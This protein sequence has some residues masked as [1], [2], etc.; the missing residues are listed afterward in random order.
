[1]IAELFPEFY[2]VH[3]RRIL[4]PGRT[5]RRGGFRPTF[6]MGRYLT[7]PLEHRCGDFADMRKFLRSCRYSD[8]DR[9]DKT[10]YW[11]PPEEFEKTRTGDC[12]DFA[13][14][15]W[16]QVLNMGY[17]ARFVVG[18]AGKF[19]EGHA[20]VT[21]ERDGK[22]YLL[23]ALSSVVGLQLPRISTL[24][25]HPSTSASWEGES[26]CYYAHAERDTNVPLRLLP[27]LVGEWIFIWARFWA[28]VGPR[29]PY[30]ILRRAL[31]PTPASKSRASRRSGS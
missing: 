6:P 24:R 13:A 7:A 11:Q 2:D 18:R 4:R 23:E 3:G 26:V 14:W 10:D 27:S 16:R 5:Q 15:A 1:M 9:Y 20:W 12:A 22:S 31:K 19:G 17:P 29:I 8:A 28:R 25:Y 30:T 21:F